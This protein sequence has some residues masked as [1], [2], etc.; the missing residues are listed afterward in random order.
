[1]AIISEIDEVSAYSTAAGHEGG[2]I[3]LVPLMGK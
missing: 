2:Y 1:M 3:G